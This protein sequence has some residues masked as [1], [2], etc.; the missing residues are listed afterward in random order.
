LF[1]SVFEAFSYCLVVLW[2]DKQK[3]KQKN[4]SLE[5]AVNQPFLYLPFLAK[6]D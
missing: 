4:I 5:M 2:K 3:I 6:T 1:A